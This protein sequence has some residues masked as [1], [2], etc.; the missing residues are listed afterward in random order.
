MFNFEINR[1]IHYEN[2]TLRFLNIKNKP[3]RVMYVHLP[4]PM[5]LQQS[6]IAIWLV[7]VSMHVKSNLL[8]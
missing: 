5:L 8:F 2:Y 3:I 1:D 7:V 4:L 6:S